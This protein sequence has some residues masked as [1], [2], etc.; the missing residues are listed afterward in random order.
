MLTSL[1]CLTSYIA[2]FS[3]IPRDPNDLVD[4]S[5]TRKSLKTLN[6]E[7]ARDIIKVYMNNLKE[8]R[9]GL[10]DGTLKYSKSKKN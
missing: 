4:F 10:K 2:A 8:L 9:A 1:D 3:E 6:V 5:K 7:E